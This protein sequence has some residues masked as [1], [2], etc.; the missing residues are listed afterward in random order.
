MNARAR[1]SV[2]TAPGCDSHS[3]VLPNECLYLIVFVRIALTIYKTSDK[4][5]I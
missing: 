3:R 1:G 5:H 4:L 2:D